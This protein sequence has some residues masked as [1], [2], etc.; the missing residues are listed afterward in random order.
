MSAEAYKQ[1]R[2]LYEQREA[3]VSAARD[4]DADAAVHVAKK[5]RAEQRKQDLS[6]LSFG[7]DDDEEAEFELPLPVNAK[8]KAKST[9]EV[10]PATAA[11]AASAANGAP[12]TAAAISAGR[13]A[14]SK[15]PTVNTDFL[16]DRAR[17]DAEARLRA[18]LEAQ[19]AAKLESERK[20]QIEITFSYWDGSGHRSSVRV[21]KGATIEQFLERCRAQLADRFAELRKV[22]PDSLLYI[23][24]DLI[25]PHHYSFHDLIVTKA[26]GKSGPLFH[27][28]VHDDVRLSADARVEKDESHAGKVLTRAWYE[29]NKHIFPASRW[30]VYDPAKSFGKYT[31]AGGELR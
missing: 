19:W 23:K 29:R 8:A 12:A 28:D 2:M 16:P 18:S 3:A 26:R 25:I 9:A 11:A 24:E 27:F 20:E 1:Q 10:A 15:D 5:R 17:E 13:P 30:E 31:I 6:V 14:V 7:V 22:G 21:A 4:L